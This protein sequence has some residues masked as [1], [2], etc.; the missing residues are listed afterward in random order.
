MRGNGT[1]WS[2]ERTI[3]PLFAPFSFRVWQRLPPTCLPLV[4]QPSILIILNTPSPLVRDPVT[5]RVV[6]S[7][8]VSIRRPSSK[9]PSPKNPISFYPSSMLAYPSRIESNL[10]RILLQCKRCCFSHSGSHIG[11]EVHLQYGIR[12]SGSSAATRRENA[13]S[14]IWALILAGKLF[15]LAFETCIDSD[16]HNM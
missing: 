13:N 8:L 5:S 14:G 15:H 1:H 16:S 2:D 10:I 6:L 9:N 7:F 3:K 12:G 4:S 11:S